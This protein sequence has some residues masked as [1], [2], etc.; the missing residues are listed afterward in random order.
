M[1]EG[2]SV[3]EASLYEEAP[4]RGAPSLGTLE[5]TLRK[6]GTQAS[7]SMGAPFHMRGSWYVEG[8]LCTGDFDR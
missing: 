2:G 8:V 6:S 5:D 7:L 3:D 1:D 4:W